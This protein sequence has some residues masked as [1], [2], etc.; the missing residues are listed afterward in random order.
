MWLARSLQE[1]FDLVKEI[2]SMDLTIPLNNI[3]HRIPPALEKKFRD[4]MPAV[5][6]NATN[7]T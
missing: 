5:Q 7:A 6:H 1:S 3:S 4:L 2:Y